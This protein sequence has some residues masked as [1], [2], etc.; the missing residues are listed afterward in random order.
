MELDLNS[1][2]AQ[3][4]EHL[5]T[6]RMVVFPSLP[7]AGDISAT[8]YWD[9]SHNPDFKSF[10]AAAEAAG[11]RMIT[12]FSREL[13]DDLIDATLGQ[14]AELNLDRDERRSLESRLKEMRAFSG[15]TGEIELSFDLGARVFVFD[16]QTEWFSDLNELIDQ[17]EDTYESH[18][19]D[20]DNDD[21]L[22]LGGG[23][24]PRN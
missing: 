2:R 8:V 7:R 3:I 18:E 4:E 22:P 15:F 16:L 21:D 6:R 23:Y 19:G 12:L 1:L 9:T 20:E 14:L 13:D 11:V 17:I 24:F 10:V 5:E